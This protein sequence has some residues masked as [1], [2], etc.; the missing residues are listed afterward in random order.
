MALIRG[1]YTEASSETIEPTLNEDQNATKFLES[2]AS[3]MKKRCVFVCNDGCG[4]GLFGIGPSHLQIGD[5]LLPNNKLQCFI[6]R[7]HESIG[8]ERNFVK[9]P[10][11]T[12]PY[13][14]VGD[15]VVSIYGISL[16]SV[17]NWDSYDEITLK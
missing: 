1:F 14:L 7:G 12:A 4:G 6:L 3:M 8:R 9:R 5:Q 11:C 15:C 16:F 13:E 2:V 10:K 17:H